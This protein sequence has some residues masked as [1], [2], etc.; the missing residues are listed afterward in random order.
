LKAQV[1]RGKAVSAIDYL[2]AKASQEKW[3]K[4]L[5]KESPASMRC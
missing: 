5:P 3:R 4:A 2:A 1:E